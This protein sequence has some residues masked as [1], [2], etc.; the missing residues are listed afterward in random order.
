MKVNQRIGQV[1]YKPSNIMLPQL[2]YELYLTN[3]LM[4]YYAI[5]Q[6]NLLDHMVYFET[7]SITFFFVTWKKLSPL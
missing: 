3:N 7:T 6:N 4:H 5:L 2:S 1:T